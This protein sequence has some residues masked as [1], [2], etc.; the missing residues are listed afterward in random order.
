MRSR[1]L[2]P[3]AERFTDEDGVNRTRTISVQEQI[4]MLPDTWKPVDLIDDK[5]LECEDGY[6]VQLIPYDAGDHIA[7]EYRKKIDLQKVKYEIN[8]L[9]D[10]LSDGD[11]KIVKCYEATLLNEALPYDIAGLHEEREVLR[12]R[13][14]ELENYYNGI[15][16]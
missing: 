1:I 13:I 7:Y 5:Q 3:L 6:V 4:N 14:N 15:Y 16:R 9:K 10:Q 8:S 12:N 11:Y 2:E